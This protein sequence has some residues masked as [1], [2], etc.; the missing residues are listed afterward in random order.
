MVIIP[1]ASVASRGINV[2]P[3]SNSNQL[4]SIYMHTPVL[5]QEKYSL[6][7][8]TM[9]QFKLTQQRKQRITN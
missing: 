3:I 9:I 7:L 2:F 5:T 1:A 6:T 4:C 8:I